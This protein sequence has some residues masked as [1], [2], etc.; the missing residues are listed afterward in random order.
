MISGRPKEAEDKELQKLFDDDVTRLS[1]EQAGYLNIDHSAGLRHLKAMGKLLRV[2]R[3]V[4]RYSDWGWGSVTASSLFTGHR[5]STCQS[6]CNVL[7]LAKISEKSKIY[8]I[9]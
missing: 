2:D 7:S 9:T 4:A 5:I 1:Q 3:W 6:H 8:E